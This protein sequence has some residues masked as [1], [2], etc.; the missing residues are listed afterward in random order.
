MQEKKQNA[1]APLD[2]TP[3]S[4]KLYAQNLAHAQ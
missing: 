3:P 1:S 2:P 4:P